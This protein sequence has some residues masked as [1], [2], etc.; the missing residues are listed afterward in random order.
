MG[1]LLSAIVS[2]FF[3][4]AANSVTSTVSKASEKEFQKQLENKDALQQAM[5]ATRHTLPDD[6]RAACNKLAKQGHLLKLQEEAP[7]LQLLSDESFLSSFVDWF[8]VGNIEEGNEIKT[9]LL[10]TIEAALVKGG[11]GSERI[12]FL[13]NGFLQTIDKAIFSD[14]VLSNW[15]HQL[16]LD[17]L[18]MQVAELQHLA[19]EAAG[20]YSKEKQ[21]C[22]LDSYCNK[23]LDAW[24]IIDLS[25]LPEGDTHLATQKLL[26]RQLY[27]PLRI[28]TELKRDNDEGDEIGE[29]DTLLKLEQK[30]ESRRLQEAG[31]MSFDEPD[32]ETG[33]TRFAVGQRLSEFKRQV[34]LGD[35]GGGKT[36]MLR[37]MAT[38]YLL[39]YK[40]D[41]AFGLVPDTETLPER[42]WI[43][44]LIRCRDLGDADLCRSFGDFL[45]QHLNK[46]ELHHE[47]AEIMRTIILDRIAKGEVLLLIDGLDEITDPKIRVTFCQE[48]E[49]TA[50][51]YP[52]V[53]VI[54]TS[55]IVGYRDMP[56]RMN[57]G[58]EHS[59]IAELNRDDKDLFAKRWVEVTEQQH[60][61]M[62]QAK[63][64]QDLIDA[65]HSSNRIE[66]LTGNPMLLTTLA[67][68]KRKVGK[69][70][71]RR[72][73]L[74]AEAVAVLLNWNPLH[75]IIDEDEAIP[76][77]GYIAYEMCHRGV[78][79]LSDDEIHDLLDRVRKDYPNKRAIKRN[80]S[81]DFLKLLEARSSII[82]RSGGIWQ[83]NSQEKPIWEFRH[84]TFQEY[85]ASNALINGCYPARDKSK[86][87]AE[88]IAPLAG[89][90]EKIKLEFGPDDEL[91]VRESWHEALRL[92][93]A[94]CSDDDIDEV[95]QS[96]LTPLSE[97]DSDKTSRPRSVLAGHCLADEPNVSED[98]AK[99]VLA[100]F[101][102]HIT[103]SDGFGK[104]EN[105]PLTRAA[106]DINISLWNPLLESKLMDEF[107]QRGSRE[108]QCIGSIWADL[109]REK[110]QNNE[111]SK[112]EEIEE[113][114]SRLGSDD[115]LELIAASLGVMEKAFRNE[116]R[117]L[118]TAAPILLGLLN[119]PCA[120]KQHAA[121][122]ALGWLVRRPQE[123]PV[124]V[125]SD[126]NVDQLC[127]VLSNINEE[128][129]HTKRWIITILSQVK[130]PSARVLPLVIKALDSQDIDLQSG[131]IRALGVLNDTA[132][133]PHLI[134]KMKNSKGAVR[135]DCLKALG[136]LDSDEETIS[137]LLLELKQ[138]HRVGKIELVRALYFKK[139][140][141]ILPALVD[142]LDNS[143]ESLLRN[144]FH[145]LG[146]QGDKKAVEPIISCLKANDGFGFPTFEAA[147]KALVLLS[148]PR[149]IEYLKSYLQHEELDR[150]IGALEVLASVIEN[151]DV[152]LILTQ[153]FDDQ[154]PWIDPKVPI[155]TSR[156]QEASGVLDIS[157]DE[158]RALYQSIAGDFG[159]TIANG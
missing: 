34:V 69:L 46:T 8:M 142:L 154:Y 127:D 75:T 94:D 97:E 116:G 120:A 5:N 71:T 54:V 106:I 70:P 91:V 3:N 82:I 92:L 12:E 14:P 31:H 89:Q 111:V 80:S 146:Y 130:K 115:S 17:Y 23:A 84:L 7:L 137:A 37:W 65:L 131:A 114:T 41:S 9:H 44:V 30:R 36:T 45:A 102:R 40:R 149:G 150:R 153:D 13:R 124:W 104:G 107:R 112:D 20:I 81:E 105:T 16:G 58:F 50:A 62:E 64:T 26:L 56:Y 67:L 59:I 135:S 55:R 143:R 156:I 57:S 155:S 148:D 47:D 139:D 99:E 158:A 87:L 4:V 38:A 159:L 32:S 121:A 152:K 144:V 88:V 27:L 21:L 86:S 2:Y 22:A 24:D 138:S 126:A 18:R 141:R 15:R 53:P 35:P 83:N 147:G 42:N 140:S 134:S 108:R 66:R 95:L 109:Q 11:I 98:V 151:E 43:P 85:L 122:W 19:A 61:P 129:V 117:V 110:W 133:L 100:G 157:I 132:A 10:D 96:I 39:K 63:R 52:K 60:P 73:K 136:R 119:S 145:A 79:Q 29:D 113:I 74:Y 125:P 77:L 93:V 33:Q 123:D 103:D 76:Q 25:N 49:R 48:L 1:M 28:E 128:E 72:T 78:Q 118:A 90:I 101:A 68:V 6:L 51:R